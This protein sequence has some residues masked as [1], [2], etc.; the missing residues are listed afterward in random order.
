LRL[1]RRRAR[2][3]LRRARRHR[4][5]PNSAQLR[6]VAWLVSRKRSVTRREASLQTQPGGPGLR[7][8]S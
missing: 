1:L 3:C 6:R 8:R 5:S 4:R 7:I 2:S